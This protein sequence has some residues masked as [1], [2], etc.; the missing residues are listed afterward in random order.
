M[1]TYT[2]GTLHSC[3]KRRPLAATRM[4]LE[5]LILS[6]ASQKE[7]D[8]YHRMSL[9]CGTQNRA[10]ANLCTKQKEIHREHTCG[11]QG[12]GGGGGMEWDLGVGRCKLLHAVWMNKGLPLNTGN[13][14]QYPVINRS[15][16]E[17]SKIGMYTHVSEKAMAPHSSTLAWKTPWME[18]PGGL[19][20]MGSLRVGHN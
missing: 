15:R 1:A 10:Q 3:E 12:E 9:I 16:K 19:Q 11:Y 7:K 4:Q 8:K 20:S 18:E 17:Q 14:I 6:E 13:Y 2:R 5:T